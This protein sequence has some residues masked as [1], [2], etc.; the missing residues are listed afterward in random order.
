M[1]TANKSANKPYGKVSYADPGYQ[2]DGKARYPIDSAAHCRAAWSYINQSGT[3][4]L[5]PLVNWHG[6]AVASRQPRRD[7][8]LIFQVKHQTWWKGLRT[9]HIVWKVNFI[10]QTKKAKSS[11]PKR[12]SRSLSRKLKSLRTPKRQTISRLKKLI[13]QTELDRILQKRLKR[14]EDQLLKKYADYDKRVEE[15]EGFRKL[16]DEKGNRR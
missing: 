8:V 6:S 1:A 10:C 12:P 3:L 2:E 13:S 15:S 7:S 4:Q 11:K 14:Q 16:Q 9:A 5:I